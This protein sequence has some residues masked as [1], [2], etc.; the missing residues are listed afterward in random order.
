[1]SICNHALLV[2]RAA[3]ACKGLNLRLNHLPVVLAVGEAKP[4]KCKVIASYLGTSDTATFNRLKL[5]CK[6]GEYVYKDRLLYR[7]TPAGQQVYD[8]FISAYNKSCGAMYAD[9]RAE[10][11]KELTGNKLN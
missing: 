7:L 10:I 5:A 9:M 1:M 4:P 2:Y 8:R 3:K 6:V 11:T